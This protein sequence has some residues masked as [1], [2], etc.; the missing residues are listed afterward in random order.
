MGLQGDSL[1][2]RRSSGKVSY[3]VFS[4]VSYTPGAGTMAGRFA[5]SALWPQPWQSTT[6]Q[7]ELRG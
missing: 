5:G 6:G 4:G 3:K 7:G 2:H 1:R